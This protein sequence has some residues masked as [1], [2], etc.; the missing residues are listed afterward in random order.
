VFILHWQFVRQ[1][2]WLCVPLKVLSQLSKIGY[3]PVCVLSSTI[4]ELDD[5]SRLS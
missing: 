5:Q 2:S 3:S 1:C 4:T